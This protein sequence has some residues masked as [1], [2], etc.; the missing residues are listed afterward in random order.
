MEGEEASEAISA[1]L[2][3]SGERHFATARDAEILARMTREELCG[4]RVRIRE[5]ELVTLL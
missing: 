5:G 3:D 2:L 4:R 1:C